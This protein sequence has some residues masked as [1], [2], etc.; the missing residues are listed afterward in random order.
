LLAYADL[1]AEG[2][3]RANE[4]AAELY[5]RFLSTEFES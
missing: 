4:A 1:L 3:D 5:T 2:H